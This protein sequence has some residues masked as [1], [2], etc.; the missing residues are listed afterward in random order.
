MIIKK[1]Y[2]YDSFQYEEGCWYILQGIVRPCIYMCENN[3]LDITWMVDKTLS[4]WQWI[5]DDLQILQ[6][7]LTGEK[8]M[9]STF[10]SK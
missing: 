2:Q 3:I 5:S 7:F 9:L 4:G 1:K 10:V 8:H 6:S